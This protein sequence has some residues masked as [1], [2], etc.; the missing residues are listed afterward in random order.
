MAQDPLAHVDEGDTSGSVAP[1]G[2]AGQAC[3]QL[4]QFAVSDETSRHDSP[5]PAYG[6][7]QLGVAQLP[8]THAP[9]PWFTAMLEVSVCEKQ[10]C[11]QLPQCQTAVARFAQL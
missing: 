3:P 6:A 2:A 1:V 10:P 11:A 9:N 7:K 5:Q 8:L 4:P